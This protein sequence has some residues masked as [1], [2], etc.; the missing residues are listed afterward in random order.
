MQMV[1]NTQQGVQTVVAVFFESPAVVAEMVGLR[2][3]SLLNVFQKIAPLLVELQL[4]VSALAERNFVVTP[5]VE[6]Q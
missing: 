6:P 4:V 5:L 2:L 3:I 1:E